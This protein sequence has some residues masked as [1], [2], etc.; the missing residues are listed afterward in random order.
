MGVSE[1]AEGQRTL[2]PAYTL[3]QG[4]PPLFPIPHFREVVLR[5]TQ[6]LNAQT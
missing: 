2:L 6:V 5:P 1:A 4:I 3:H